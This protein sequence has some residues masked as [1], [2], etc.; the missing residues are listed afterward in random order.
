MSLSEEKEETSNNDDAD[1]EN[2]DKN[3]NLEDISKKES[4]LDE[5][6]SGKTHSDETE[7]KVKNIASVLVIVSMAE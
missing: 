6:T 3:N 1:G 2:L 7:N 4:D 5:D